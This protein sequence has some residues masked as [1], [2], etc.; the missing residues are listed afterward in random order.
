MGGPT[1]VAQDRQVM[2]QSS[3]KTWST[4]E[5]KGKP[6]Q[7]SSLETPMNNFKKAEI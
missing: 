6:L 5:G 4:G 2:V 1:G 7:Y 3:D